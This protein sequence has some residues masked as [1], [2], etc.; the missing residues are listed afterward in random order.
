MIKLDKIINNTD[1]E[2]REKLSGPLKGT[3]VLELGAFIIAPHTA[4]HLANMGA[5]VIKI[6]HPVRGEPTRGLR[7]LSILPQTKL[8]P[9]WEKDNTNKKSI[10]LDLTKEAGKEILY[11]LVKNIDVFV[12]NLQSEVLRRLGVDYETLAQINPQLVYALATGWGLRGPDKDQP[13]FDLAVWAR[14]G[15]MGSLGEPDSPPVPCLPGLGDQMASLALAYGTM[16]ALFHREK[17]GEGQMVHVSL[18]GTLVDIGSVNLQACLFAD[19]QDLPRVSRKDAI[20]P[21]WNTYKTKD[22]RWIQL[23]ML[24]TDP[25][26]HDFCQVLGIQEMENDP[27]FISHHQRCEVNGRFLIPILDEIFAAKSLAEWAERFKGQKI[28]WGCV[29]T[30]G[31]VAVDT[32]LLENDYIVKID[33]PSVGQVDLVGPP[34]QLSK[35]PGSIE[36]LA[37]ELG[38]HTE[39]ILL[40]IGYTWEDIGKLKEDQV[41]N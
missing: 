28:I 31:Q 38:E 6:E 37:P 11:R 34:V 41:I 40:Q 10:G 18:L 17:T 4:V 13:A 19:G 21:L 23:A 2:I 15:L 36:T 30:Y 22:N 8:N 20:N 1:L 24:Q 29:N 14:S 7:P 3:K 5:E 16:L 26:W 12:T 32:Q 35:T 33:H 25:S 27:R 39:E 9:T